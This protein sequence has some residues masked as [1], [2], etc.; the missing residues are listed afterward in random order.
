[1]EAA[2]SARCVSAVRSTR[3]VIALGALKRIPEPREMYGLTYFSMKDIWLFETSPSEDPMP[4]ELCRRHEDH[5]EYH[6]HHLRLNFPYLEIL[7]VGT[8]QANVHPNCRC[9]L[10]RLTEEVKE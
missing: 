6:G 4:C 5:G 9:Y 1:M 3:A 7:D 10:I 8:I 2:Q